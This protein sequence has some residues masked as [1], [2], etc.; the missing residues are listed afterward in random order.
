QTTVAYIVRWIG[1]LR[2]YDGV[3][4][5]VEFDDPIGQKTGMYR[6]CELFRA[7]PNHAGFLLLPE[8]DH[9]GVTKSVNNEQP[10]RHPQDESGMMKRKDVGM[11][12]E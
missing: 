6:E 1:R 3:Y 9:Q 5:G 2:G 8:V 4:A 12:K 7:A 10:T 11:E